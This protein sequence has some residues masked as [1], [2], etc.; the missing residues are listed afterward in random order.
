MTLC[1]IFSRFNLPCDGQVAQV[2]TAYLMQLF[3]KRWEKDACLGMTQ[4]VMKYRTAI[5]SKHLRSRSRS[6]NTGA[7]LSPAFSRAQ[8]AW[9]SLQGVFRV[10]GTQTGADRSVPHRPDTRRNYPTHRLVWRLVRW[11]IPLSVM[12]LA[13]GWQH[14]HTLAADW[15]WWHCMAL[16]ALTPLLL[17]GPQALAS[18]FFFCSFINFFRIFIMAPEYPE[19]Y[20][21]KKQQKNQ[22]KT[23]SYPDLKLKPL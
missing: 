22:P 8:S 3:H 9:P 10:G 17:R 5:K 11:G 23:S 13:F 6:W 14:F 12:V 2:I 19:Q 7:I 16:H 4:V 15:R 1:E 21:K 18:S 20:I